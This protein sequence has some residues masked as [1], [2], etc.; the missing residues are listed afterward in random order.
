MSLLYMCIALVFVSPC[1]VSSRRTIVSSA[2][3]AS[4]Q[5]RLHD[6]LV[7][8]RFLLQMEVLSQLNSPEEKQQV[9]NF[10]SF[11][12][13][14]LPEH[15]QDPFLRLLV[16]IRGV[17][18]V[19][20]LDI[21]AAA[22]D[23][24]GSEYSD[25]VVCGASSPVAVVSVASGVG[26][27]RGAVLFSKAQ[28]GYL[29]GL[30]MLF[31][32]MTV[33]AEERFVLS[34]AEVLSSS[35]V[36]TVTVTTIDVMDNI[37]MCVDKFFNC[38]HCRLHFLET[39][40]SCQFG[41]CEVKKSQ[42][43]ALQRWLWYFHNFVTESIL[44]HHL[45]KEKPDGIEN[46]Y[47]HIVHWPDGRSC[48][49]CYEYDQGDSSHRQS[50]KAINKYLQKSYW[51]PTWKLRTMHNYTPQLAHALH[52]PFQPADGIHPALDV[53]RTT[54]NTHYDD[55]LFSL[56]AVSLMGIL[57]LVMT[58]AVLSYTRRRGSRRGGRFYLM[59]R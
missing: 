18:V 37:L 6:A 54:S 29:C 23:A 12:I 55:T 38:R 7:S 20:S 56:G 27:K 1:H 10:L 48:V 16:Y 50:Q 31:H 24:F 45:G 11:V 39:Y 44:H 9:V 14:L 41:R 8:L 47:K 51:D 17:N 52:N 43:D 28:D 2:R 3:T 58:V 59:S 4:P 57:L 15:S 34:I 13:S 40:T 53:S 46:Y 30:W 5:E 36:D 26:R 49:D 33:A 35:T 42:F 19:T 21:D 32:Y 25:W 22:I